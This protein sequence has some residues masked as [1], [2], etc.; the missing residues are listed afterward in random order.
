MG[1]TWHEAVQRVAGGMW[2]QPADFAA[3]LNQIRD[4]IA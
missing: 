2:D 1:Y 4:A 3:W